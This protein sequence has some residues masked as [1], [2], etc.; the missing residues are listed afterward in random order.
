M[1]VKS[2]IFLGALLILLPWI[3]I[4]VSPRLRTKINKIIFVWILIQFLGCFILFVTSGSPWTPWHPISTVI[5]TAIIVA[6]IIEV[7][8]LLIKV[9]L[10]KLKRR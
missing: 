5:Q 10:K 3:L 7:S 6:I 9:I 1:Y 2:I 4:I 8:Y